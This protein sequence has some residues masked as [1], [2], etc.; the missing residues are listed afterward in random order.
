[1]N[2]LNGSF[3]LLDKLQNNESSQ[4]INQQIES[5]IDD[6]FGDIPF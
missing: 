2:G 6:D 4:N 1:V 3:Q 5:S